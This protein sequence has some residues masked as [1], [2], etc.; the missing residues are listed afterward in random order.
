LVQKAIE[1]LSQLQILEVSEALYLPS[2]LRVLLPGNQL[3]SFQNSHPMFDELIKLVLRNFG[4]IFDYYVTISEKVLAM[5]LNQSEREIIEKLQK[6]HELG[7]V[8]YVGQKNKPQMRLNGPRVRADYIKID[9]VLLR[10][11]REMEEEKLEAMIAYAENEN[12]CRSRK[13][14]AYFDEDDVIDCCSCDVCKEKMVIYW[15]SEKIQ[16]LVR[17]LEKLNWEKACTVKELTK[18]VEGYKEEEL[19]KAFRIL[20]D[21]GILQLNSQ[22]LLIWASKKA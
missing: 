3:Y 7:I 4:G 13:L 12:L 16:K 10:N 22:Q 14:L 8:D 1:V 6:L 21:K 18:R 9:Q 5:K 20:V 11:R 15:T 19:A 2:R 17:V